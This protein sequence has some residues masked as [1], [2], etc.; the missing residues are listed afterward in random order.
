MHPD[1]RIARLGHVLQQRPVQMVEREGPVREA[2]VALL[3]RP[4]DQ[5]EVLLIKRS[6][7][8]TDPWSGHMALPGGR[9]EP[10]DIDLL[11]TALREAYEEIG[12]QAL[13]ADRLGALDEVTP[14]TPRLPPIVIAPFVLAVPAEAT[15]HPDPAE[16]DAALWVPLPALADE[17]A[18]DEL[19]IELE[20]L[21]RSFPAYR[22]LDYVIWGLTHRILQQFMEA[23]AEANLV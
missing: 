8:E 23:A 12:I 20:G 3:V 22:Y 10:G 14:R 2:A 16:V 15:A 1:P 4:R 21:A 5:L 6:E 7:H 18:T 19:I 9:R 13:A 17:R 11:A